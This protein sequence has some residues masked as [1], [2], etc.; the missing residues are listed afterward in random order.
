MVSKSIRCIRTVSDWTL[1]SEV[2]FNHGD[3]GV[4]SGELG[5]SILGIL[6]VLVENVCSPGGCDLSCKRLELRSVPV[7]FQRTDRPFM[8]ERTATA[9]IAPTTL[10][11]ARTGE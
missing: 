9:S 4:D 10:N 7:A 11:L 3:T 8:A 5:T 1:L 6:F 2:I